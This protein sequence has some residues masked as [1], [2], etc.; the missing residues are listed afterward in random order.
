MKTGNNQGLSPRQASVKLVFNA[1]GQDLKPGDPGDVLL[2]LKNEIPDSS[3]IYKLYKDEED[4]KNA[5]KFATEKEKQG[6][7]LYMITDDPDII[8]VLALPD[9]YETAIKIMEPLL[10][11]DFFER[12]WAADL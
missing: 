4:V 1:A 12:F 7:K 9:G 2:F 3:F 8:H 11:Y 6:H 5:R 10:K